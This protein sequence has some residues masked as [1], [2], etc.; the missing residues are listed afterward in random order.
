MN[1]PPTTS[2]PLKGECG[3]CSSK[4]RRLLHRLWMRGMNRHLTR[5]ERTVRE[6]A[7]ARKR[8]RDALDHCSIVDKIKRLGLE[9][10]FEASNSKY[11]GMNHNHN[12][13]VSNKKEELNGFGGGQGKVKTE[14]MSLTPPVN[15]N[16]N[17]HA[18]LPNR[19][20]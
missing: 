18:K 15:K 9:G 8:A 3:N 5:V 6:A 20:A 12:N 19:V 16:G 2:F 7:L 17:N 13:V 10:T 1:P 11:L 14:A 4:E